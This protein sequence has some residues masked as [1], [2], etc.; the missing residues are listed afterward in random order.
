MSS[1][2]EAVYMT[3]VRNILITGATRG[4]G[5][6]FSERMASLGHRIILSDI[7]TKAANVFDESESGSQLVDQL[8][9]MTDK[10]ELL[11]ADL[12][13][14][15]ASSA[16]LN[17][18]WRILGHIDVII[19]NAGGDIVSDPK[20]YADA[21][22]TKPPVNNSQMPPEHHEEVYQRNYLTCWNTVTPLIPKMAERGFGKIITVSSVNASFGMPTETAYSAAKAAVVQLTRSIA[23]ERRD[24]GISA[25]CLMLGPVKTGR[26]Q[27]TLKNRSKHDLE[28]FDATGRLTRIAEPDDAADVMEF[29]VGQK[30]DYIS[31]QV[32]RVDGGKFPQP[33]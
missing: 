32:I 21:A 29:L 4:L 8:R 20:G 28:A 17:E 1:V 2:E 33:V 9:Q 27:A 24:D 16:M 19:A 18:A 5:K 14:H 12:T 26:F 31:G 6:A 22:G 23:S 3:N 25:N 15:T 30:S 10:V 7:S 11:E 13:D